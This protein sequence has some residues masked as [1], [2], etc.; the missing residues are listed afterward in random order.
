V[1]ALTR[2]KTTLITKIILKD[3]KGFKEATLNLGPFSVVVGSNA[4]GKSNIRDALR[5]IHGIGR[6]YTLA[7]II[8]GKFGAGGQTE[9]Q[10]IRGSGPELIRFGQEGFSLTVFGKLL[11]IPDPRRSETHFTYHIEVVADRETRTGFRVKEEELLYNHYSPNYQDSLFTSRPGHSDPVQDQD[12]DGHLL[13]RMKKTGEQRKFGLRIAAR[14]DQPAIIQI[15][16]EK[17]VIR[18]HNQLIFDV[19]EEFESIRF[20]DLVPD[21]MRQSAF[22]GQQ[23][24][25]DSGENL[26]TVLQGICEDPERADILYQ[27]IRELTPLDVRKLEFVKDTVTGR[28]QFRIIEENE[29]AIS[30]YSASDGT[31]RF[32]AM[33]AALL[34]DQPAK[35][36]FFE[37]IDNGIHPARLKLLVDLIESVTSDGT[38]QVLTTTHSPELISMVS[39]DTFKNMSVVVRVPDK[40]YSQIRRVSELPN[41]KQL[42]DTQGLNRLLTSGWFEDMVALEQDE[43][44]ACAA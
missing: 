10:P 13:L 37:E 12:D 29:A 25:G 17:R 7:E 4:A 32:L 27:W 44:E 21:A 24:L 11:A 9:W 1:V 26:S 38:I 30:A 36:Y 16:D 35:F 6:G 40:N 18:S 22:P 31:L 5:F 3:F 42:R 20:L 34:G 14:H 41:L 23:T 2:W 43:P 15:P 28:V 33:L 8:G 19:L 39:E